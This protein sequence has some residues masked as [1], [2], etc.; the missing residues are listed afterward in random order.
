MSSYINYYNIMITKFNKIIYHDH[1]LYFHDWLYFFAS[2]VKNSR[3]YL[4]GHTCVGAEHNFS[5]LKLLY[6]KYS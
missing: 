4:F 1:C 5:M 6:A 3:Y 2:W